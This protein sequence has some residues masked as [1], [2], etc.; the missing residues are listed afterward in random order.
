MKAFFKYK[1]LLVALVTTSEWISGVQ[2]DFGDYVDP[3]F[4]CPA[5]TTCP[6]ICAASR[7]DCPTNC[8][9]G[10]ELCANG[11]CAKSCDSNVENPCSSCSKRSVACPKVVDLST[12]CQDNY[13]AQYQAFDECAETE[14]EAE[15]AARSVT[16][17][18]GP[19]VFAYVWVSVLTTLMLLWCAWNQRWRP[20]PA[21]H[22]ESKNQ[23]DDEPALYQVG[24]RNH[25][26][27][28]ILYVL[29]LITFGGW[30]A[31]LAFL[32]IQYYALDGSKYLSGRKV[33]FVD[34]EQLLKTFIV[35]I[36][37]SS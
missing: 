18:D 26:F 34:E 3:T 37:A 5:T 35:S 20:A 36:P 29:T 25:W 19:Y 12:S 32:T 10:F 24:Y 8:D 23:Q 27:G 14:L 17:S 30:I 22:V 11:A 16:F 4:A 9:P 6:I 21:V 31:A 13:S 33:H 2:G 1:F 28:S 7:N 15:I